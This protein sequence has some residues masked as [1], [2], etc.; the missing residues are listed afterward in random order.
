V[1]PLLC[2][3][4]AQPYWPDMGGM[5]APAVAVPA[6]RAVIHPVAG[7]PWPTGSAD[8]TT[9]AARA[10]KEPLRV[11]PASAQTRMERDTRLRAGPAMGAADST[12]HPENSTYFNRLFVWPLDSRSNYLREIELASE[13]HQAKVKLRRE[14]AQVRLGGAVEAAGSR[15]A[16]CYLRVASVSG[17]R[18][19]TRR[20]I[21]MTACGVRGALQRHL[22]SRVAGSHVPG[23]EELEA[24][25]ELPSGGAGGGG[26]AA[27]AAAA[28][29][30]SEEQVDG[31]TEERAYALFTHEY[32]HAVHHIWQSQKS[33]VRR[34]GGTHELLKQVKLRVVPRLLPPPSPFPRGRAYPVILG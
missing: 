15:S 23:G 16:C 7:A 4:R 20:A 1:S 21:A 30:M 32:H 8:G 31:R 13:E 29:W 17:P 12:T 3:E 24:L 33:A 25:D 11:L 28:A 27:A 34:A 14:S 9:Q 6:L 5:A 22:V 18:G 19:V 26:A 2:R 10:A